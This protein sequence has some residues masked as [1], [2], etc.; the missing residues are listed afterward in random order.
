MGKIGRALA[1]ALL[2]CLMLLGTAVPVLAAQASVAYEGG[3]EG[4]V[5]LPGEDLF[6]NF[7]G[8]MPGDT[9]EQTVEIRNAL[10]GKN[11]VKIYLRGETSGRNDEEAADFLSR[12]T[13]KIYH[14]DLLIAQG[15]ANAVQP[16]ESV[17]LGQFPSGGSTALKVVLE[18]PAELGNDFADRAGEVVWVFSAEEIPPAVGPQTGDKTPIVLLV[19]L[20]LVS[21][22]GM[23]VLLTRRKP[24]SK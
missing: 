23:A 5:F 13:L 19:T 9:L 18:V 21:L 15:K 20:L 17:L 12:M 8:V 6:P 3:A 24:R 4:F 1:P 22:L 16:E 11:T 14:G 10:S 7:K 2:C